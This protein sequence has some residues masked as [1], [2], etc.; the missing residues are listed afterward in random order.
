MAPSSTADGRL[1]EACA[2]SVCGQSH[3]TPTHME[4]LGSNGLN[5]STL[6]GRWRLAE[7]CAAQRTTSL[8]YYS[9][10]RSWCALLLAI[11]TLNNTQAG[12]L[13]QRLVLQGL[14]CHGANFS[15]RLL[16]PGQR[17][18]HRSTGIPGT[19]V[20][21]L[22]RWQRSLLKAQ[23]SSQSWIS[24]DKRT[25]RAQR[26]NTPFSHTLQRRTRYPHS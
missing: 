9:P 12:R 25:N 22:P 2:K 18:R 11:I 20:L 4:R 16:P 21:A 19:A 17:D 23:Q 6:T 13:V 1:P 7:A 8:L 10:A 14:A 15:S 24:S 26:S 5:L 3:T